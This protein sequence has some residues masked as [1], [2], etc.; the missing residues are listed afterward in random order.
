MHFGM[1]FTSARS[2]HP[3]GLSVSLF[4]CLALSPCHPVALVLLRVRIS[5]AVVPIWP[6]VLH[7]AQVRVA[8]FLMVSFLSWRCFQSEPCAFL[9]TVVHHVATGNPLKDEANR[10]KNAG[11]FNHGEGTQAF[12]EFNQTTDCCVPIVAMGDV[13]TYQHGAGDN[14]QGQWGYA[15]GPQF[16]GGC[17]DL[18]TNTTFGINGGKTKSNKNNG[19]P[20]GERATIQKDKPQGCAGQCKAIC[21]DLDNYKITINDSK[22]PPEHRAAV[23]GE[24]IH[25]DYLFFEQDRDFCAVEGDSNGGVCYLTLCTAYCRGALIPIVSCATKLRSP[26]FERV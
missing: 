25:L 13:G 15:E 23:I 3:P 1:A 2:L 4:R 11:Q 12:A 5:W 9:H 17:L 8:P 22:M 7:S 26:V 16:F 10:G 19:F 14:Q 18:C 6:L 24:A 21:S 20:G